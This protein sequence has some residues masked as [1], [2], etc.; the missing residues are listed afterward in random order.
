MIFTAEQLRDIASAMN[1]G[2]DAIDKQ[3]PSWGLRV[4]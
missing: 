2:A 3:R 4:K 1:D